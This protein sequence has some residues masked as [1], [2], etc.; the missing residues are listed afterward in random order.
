MYR[1]IIDNQIESTPLD[2]GDVQVSATFDGHL[3]SREFSASFTFMGEAYSYLLDLVENGDPCSLVDVQID[4]RK[5]NAEA[6]SL[7]DILV[8]RLDEIEFIEETRFAVA[9]LRREAFKGLLESFGDNSYPIS[10]EEY[11]DFFSMIDG[12][13]VLAGIEVGGLTQLTLIDASSSEAVRVKDL[14]AH[15]VSQVV[16]KQT[17]IS[18]KVFE[19]PYKRNIWRVES[20]PKLGTGNYIEITFDTSFGSSYRARVSGETEDARETVLLLRNALLYVAS[21]QSEEEILHRIA[22]ITASGVQQDGT[23]TIQLFSD[24]QISNLVLSSDLALNTEE[25]EVQAYSWGLRDLF[26]TPKGLASGTQVDITLNDLLSELKRFNMSYQYL[27]ADGIFRIDTPEEFESDTITANPPNGPGEKSLAREY[28]M[29]ELSLSDANQERGVN[30]DSYG[31]KVYMPPGTVDQ[32]TI[33]QDEYFIYPFSAYDF[34]GNY[35][36]E[37]GVYVVPINS[38]ADI[39]VFFNAPVNHV[40]E[41]S[42]YVILDV[43]LTRAGNTSIIGEIEFFIPGIYSGEVSNFSFIS[44]KGDQIKLSLNRILNEDKNSIGG[45]LRVFPGSYFLFTHKSCVTST[46]GTQVLKVLDNCANIIEIANKEGFYWGAGSLL[47]SALQ[48]REQVAGTEEQNEFND[49]YFFV[50]FNSLTEDS[51]ERF[52][53]EFFNDQG[54]L[55][56]FGVND[57]MYFYNLPLRLLY[58]REFWRESI[59]YPA[60]V[61]T[62]SFFTS[63]EKDADTW[64]YSHS[65]GLSES[66]APATQSRKWVYRYNTILSPE[67][68]K[69]VQQEGGIGSLLFAISKQ[70]KYKQIDFSLRTGASTVQL[71]AE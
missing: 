9:N 31:A 59:P 49:T 5:T 21:E 67:E 58:A 68:F 16:G 60:Y 14:L 28:L 50:L 33:E 36:N 38:E 27:P 22:R 13:N 45:G 12:E 63:V 69:A 37:S 32:T 26:V 10:G 66:L 3:Y 11:F 44:Q 46:S 23:A 48:R 53:K 71:F 47:E 42:F 43:E 19:T 17:Q 1:F 35:N 8:F 65:N 52:L 29:R 2:W 64:N 61:N 41:D 34:R 7:F 6:W 54:S 51:P 70:G 39:E 30:L 57:R 20:I 15:L 24:Y 62:F 18:S 25:T 56:E 55:C 4:Y 40:F